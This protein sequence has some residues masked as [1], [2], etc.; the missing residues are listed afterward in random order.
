MKHPNLDY[1]KLRACIQEAKKIANVEPNSK[2]FFV[3]FWPQEIHMKIVYV[4][5]VAI[6]ATMYI[7]QNYEYCYG[8]HN[9]SDNFKDRFSKKQLPDIDEY[10]LYPYLWDS[11]MVSEYKD[12]RISPKKNANPANSEKSKYKQGSD[13]FSC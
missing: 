2:E 1:M 9:P 6:N 13:R 4:I 10:R 7:F 12:N 8:I 3:Y 11:S 5:I